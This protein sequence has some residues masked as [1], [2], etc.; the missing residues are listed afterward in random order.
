MLT[1]QQQQIMDDAFS[2]S[3]D[4]FINASPANWRGVNIS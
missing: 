2:V 3:I 4:C 1:K